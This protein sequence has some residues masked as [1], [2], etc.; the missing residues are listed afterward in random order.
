M[1]PRFYAILVR[2]IEEGAQLGWRQAFKH[3]DNPDDQL[4]CERIADC[5]MDAID[6]V[7]EFEFE[8]KDEKSL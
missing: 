3:T 7:F 4:A 8:S 2:A 1:K 5:I 6:S